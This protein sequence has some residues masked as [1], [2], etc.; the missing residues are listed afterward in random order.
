MTEIDDLFSK[1]AQVA[2]PGASEPLDIPNAWLQGRTAFGGLS[3]ALA[4]AGANALNNQGAPLRSLL[5]NF[6]GPLGAGKATLSANMMRT[7]KSVTQISA[8]V[9]NNDG[10]LATRVSAAFGHDRATEKSCDTLDITQPP[11]RSTVPHVDTI[12]MAADNVIPQFLSKFDQ[13][14]DG[15]GV[16]GSNTASTTLGIWSRLREGLNDQPLLRTVMA[17]DIPPPIIMSHYSKPPLASSLSWALDFIV[18]PA[19]IKGGW[20]YLQ[21]RLD[22]AANGYCIQSGHIFDESSQLI[23][24]SRQTMVYFEK[25]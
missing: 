25:S 10:A 15:N 19:E 12:S 7:G 14:W 6:V 13:H 21:F 20:Y 9:I 24:L 2:A 23:A 8:D 18:D 3:V 16:P 22:N 11:A 17:C 1:A 5:V 4:V